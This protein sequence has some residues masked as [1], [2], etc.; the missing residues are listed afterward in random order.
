MQRNEIAHL[1]SK[2]NELSQAASDDRHAAEF[3]RNWLAEGKVVLDERGV[4][5]IIGNREDM[6]E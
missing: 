3:V 5:N 4:P 1:E 6:D 2:L